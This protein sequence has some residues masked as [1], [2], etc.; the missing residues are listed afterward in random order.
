[1]RTTPS[2]R[3]RSASAAESVSGTSASVSR[4]VVEHEAVHVRGAAGEVAQ[5]QER[6]R[7]RPVAVLEDR[8]TSGVR[9]AHGGEQVGH[10]A[11]EPVA[12]GVRVGLDRDGQFADALRQIGEQPRQ[13]APVLA[14]LR[15]QDGRVGRRVRAGPAP[16]RTG[17][18]AWHDRVARA[19][20]HELR[21]RRRR[22]G[23]L[24]DQAALAR[25][26]LAAHERE[27]QPF[28]AGRGIS[29][30]QRRQLARARPRTGTTASGGA[31]LGVWACVAGRR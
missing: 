2:D 9:A 7:V 13:L 5:Q 23:E 12:L 27:A 8:A 29:V 18:R 19:V 16:P 22:L 4:N 6:R 28:A 15:A 11:V 1:M 25:S 30:A 14:Q 10:R 17:G 3:R 31:D 20:E 26:R 24:A 21:P